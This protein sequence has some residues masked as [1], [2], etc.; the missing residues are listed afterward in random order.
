MNNNTDLPFIFI[1][2]LVDEDFYPVGDVFMIEVSPTLYIRQVA[3][4]M[5]WTMRK[6]ISD[7]GIIDDLNDFADVGATLWKL[8]KP[9]PLPRK[10]KR[11]AAKNLLEDVRREQSSLVEDLDDFLLLSR[12]FDERLPDG[13]LHLLLQLAISGV[14]GANAFQP[15]RRASAH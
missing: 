1:C 9:C 11:V 3:N 10:D 6:T 7:L 13:H 5:K 12:Y 2:Q 15:L 4:V 14:D 8:S